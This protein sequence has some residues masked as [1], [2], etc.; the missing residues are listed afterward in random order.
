MMSPWPKHEGNLEACC[1]DGRW[2]ED[3]RT[4]LAVFGGNFG[5]LKSRLD[6]YLKIMKEAIDIAREHN[7]DVVDT[8]VELFLKRSKAETQS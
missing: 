1:K 3:T 2:C 6:A 4:T 7:E 5:T 8:A